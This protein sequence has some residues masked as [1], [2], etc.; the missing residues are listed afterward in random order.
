[1][2]VC[3]KGG[4]EGAG[5]GGEGMGKGVQGSRVGQGEEEAMWGRWGRV[6]GVGWWCVV[7]A[8]SGGVVGR[9]LGVG[10]RQTNCATNKGVRGWGRGWGKWEPTRVCHRTQMSQPTKPNPTAKPK[11]HNARTNKETKRMN[12]LK[13]KPT[14]QRQRRAYAITTTMSSPCAAK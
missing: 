3:V 9:G 6:V 10:G 1:M 7:G 11:S 5:K 14:K 8:G 2:G 12:E 4:Q 13:L